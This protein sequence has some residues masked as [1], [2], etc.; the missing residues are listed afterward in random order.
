VSASNQASPNGRTRSKPPAE[1]IQGQ[2]RFNPQLG[3]ANVAIRQG[4]YGQAEQDLQN[5]EAALDTMEKS[6][7]N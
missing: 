5:A 1:F 6:L 3:A 2:L 4:N 7:G